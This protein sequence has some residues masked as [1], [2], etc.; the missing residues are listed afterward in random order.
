MLESWNDGAA[1]RTI[2]DFVDRVTTESS[3]DFVA[4]A[5]RIATFDNDGTLWSEKPVPIQLD[6]IVRHF[7][8]MAEKDPALRERQPWKAA[9]ER[10]LHWLG[11]A[12]VKHYHGDDGDLHVLLGAL[13]SSFG[14]LSVDTYEAEALDFIDHAE[15]PTLHRPYSQCAYVPMVELLR[16]LEAHGFS[17]YITSGGDRDFMRPFAMPMYGVPPERVIGSSFGLSFEETDYGG[18]VF[19]KPALD[20]FDDGP[21]KPVRIWSRIGRH[22]IIAGGNSNGDVPMLA[23]A[24]GPAHPG[25]RLLV[26]HD[27]SEREFYYTA[28]AEQAL[29]KAHA[30]GWTV[31]SIKRDWSRVF[32]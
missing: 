1:K 31:I 15:H 25:L 17:P 23:F 13:Q 5:A 32:S 20:V 7:A 11:G 10:D 22:P 2:T 16:Y 21:E 30:N 9:Y 4:P 28:G 27:D 8:A 14:G 19:Y 12:I 18:G 24:G 6:Y 26:L 29:D 3:R